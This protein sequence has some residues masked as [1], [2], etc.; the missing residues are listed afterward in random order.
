MT[1]AF[2]VPHTAEPDAIEFKVWFDEESPPA[3]I[4]ISVC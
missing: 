2:L 4:A 1:W 3:A